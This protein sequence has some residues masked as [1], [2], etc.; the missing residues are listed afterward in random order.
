MNKA[1]VICYDCE[2]V[3]MGSKDAFICPKCRARRR[4][5]KKKRK[6]EGCVQG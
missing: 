5:E 6:K 3:F 2:R 4:E 1:P